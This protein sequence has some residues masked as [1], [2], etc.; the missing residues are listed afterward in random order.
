[1]VSKTKTGE[2]AKNGHVHGQE[3]TQFQLPPAAQ[4]LLLQLQSLQQ[5][6]KAVLMQ[7]ETLSIQ[8]AEMDDALSELS[9]A[10]ANEDV[11]KAVGQIL[12]K[13]KKEDMEK[14]LK[15]NKEAAELR[16]KTLN[17]QQ[18]KI[19]EKMKELQAKLQDMLKGSIAAAE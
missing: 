13:V 2:K 14:E 9:K 17:S 18:E 15:E 3:T 7:K 6:L 12:V 1:M 8:K 10:N 4:Q 19:E 11:F 16:L 5:S